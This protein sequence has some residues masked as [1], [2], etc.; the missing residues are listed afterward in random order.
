MDASN[1]GQ[2][3]V[4]VPNFCSITNSNRKRLVSHEF[5][6]VMAEPRYKPNKYINT[7]LVPKNGQIP[8]DIE[9]L[10]SQGIFSVV[11]VDSIHDTKMGV[12]FDPNSLIQALSNLLT[13]A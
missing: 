4:N 13:D 5:H 9:I 8:E 2:R 3:E 6:G 12:L 7:L 1:P 11:T 10:A